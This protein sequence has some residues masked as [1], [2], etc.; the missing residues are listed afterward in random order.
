MIQYDSVKETREKER[1]VT[2]K[3]EGGRVSRKW[4]V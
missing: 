2:L 1:G 4:I 3:I